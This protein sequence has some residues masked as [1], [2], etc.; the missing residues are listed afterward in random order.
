MSVSLESKF[1]LLDEIATSRQVKSENLTLQSINIM[2]KEQISALEIQVSDLKALLTAKDYELK[3]LTEQDMNKPI[4]GS[5]RLNVIP[6]QLP[7]ENPSKCGDLEIKR[8]KIL[9]DKEK[10]LNKLLVCKVQ[11][12]KSFIEDYE[13]RNNHSACNKKISELERQVEIIT[14]ENESLRRK[15][16]T[17]TFIEPEETTR[18]SYINEQNKTDFSMLTDENIEIPVS[19][20]PHRLTTNFQLN[21]REEI[22]FKS[23]EA[24][25]KISNTKKSMTPGR[26]VRR[27]TCNLSDILHPSDHQSKLAKFCPSTLRKLKILKPG[28][29]IIN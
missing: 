21:Y 17:P 28:L 20:T 7:K 26:V 29:S 1:S 2:Y 10:Q 13:R 12:L 18:E 14:E 6:T 27:F 9:L 8:Y 3:L 15:F 4:L 11:E 22:N 23:E 25:P 5:Q 24:K 19:N 16:L